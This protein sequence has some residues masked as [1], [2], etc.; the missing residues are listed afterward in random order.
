MN[1]KQAEHI[2]GKIFKTA[3]TCKTIS[4]EINLIKMDKPM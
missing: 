1:K 3:K 2:M 4:L